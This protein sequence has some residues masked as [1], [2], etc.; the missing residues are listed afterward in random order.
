MTDAA[1]RARPLQSGPRRRPRAGRAAGAL[2]AAALFLSLAASDAAAHADDLDP[3]TCHG[4]PEARV[5]LESQSWWSDFD[6]PIFGGDAEHVHSGVCV[7]LRQVVS[8]PMRIDV[9][10]KLHNLQGWQRLTARVQ[11]ASNT[12]LTRTTSSAT[13]CQAHDCT[14]VNTFTVDTDKLS[15][16]RHEFRFHSEARPTPSSQEASL[17]TNG[18][19]ICIRSC[20]PSRVQAT[21]VPEGRAWYRPASGSEKGYINARFNSAAAFP[22]QGGFVPV[23]G[24]WC[25]PVRI[26]RGAGDENVERSFVSI[27]PNFHGGHQGTVLLD[28]PGT[29]T[30]NVCVDTTQLANG[31]HKLFMS[32]H[33]NSQFTGQ[34]W[35]AQV[36]PFEVAN[37]STP[38]PPP[39]PG[40]A[41][42]CSNGLDDD[43]DGLIDLGDP[44]CT[45]ASDGDES[46]VV[47]PPPP[48]GTSVRV[49]RPSAGQ[50]VSGTVRL[51][52]A[53]SS[54]VVKVDYL[55][56]GRLVAS[57]ST[58]GNG[59]AE[60]WSSRTVA[61]GAQSVTARAYAGGGGSATSDAVS[62]TVAN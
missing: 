42:A 20:E 2:L 25:A 29:F 18:W 52:V 36:I 11:D 59:F 23:S 44:G 17:A 3:N 30:G 46:N 34:L 6:A 7:P 60:D 31:R 37:G 53:A 27:D 12:L 39:P 49:V 24:T 14:L 43:G 54:D 56:G 38:P 1:C 33:S 13:L 47:S 19:Q 21:D 51:D 16:G 22:W 10:S 58:A 40:P 32:A 45:G 61:N 35:G 57:D 26:L 28:Q 15:T 50:V 55:V 8:G 5:F 48:A 4:Y 9:V 62:F 41:P